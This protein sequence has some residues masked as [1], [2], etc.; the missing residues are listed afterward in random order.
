M[1]RMHVVPPRPADDVRW[2][3]Q[4]GDAARSARRPAGFGGGGREL[5]RGNSA[6]GGSGISGPPIRKA[7][8]RA[9][10]DR[11]GECGWVK[12]VGARKDVIVA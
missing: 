9:E 10:V 5:P 1:V 3:Y 12:L 8:M 4:L 11:R 6:I 7:E 2:V